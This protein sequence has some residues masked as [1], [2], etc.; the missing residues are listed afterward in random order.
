LE[1]VTWLFE[2]FITAGEISGNNIAGNHWKREVAMDV[3]NVMSVPQYKV[4][5]HYLE[6]LACLTVSIFTKQIHP[7]WI[8]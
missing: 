2:T 6:S 5:M 1:I 3:G 7:S 4:K 8:F